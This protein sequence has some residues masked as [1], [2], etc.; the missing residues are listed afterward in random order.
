MPLSI[1]NLTPEETSGPTTL[2]K[3]ATFQKFLD[4]L[5]M[6]RLYFRRIDKLTDPFEGMMPPDLYSPSSS[7][8]AEIE[9]AAILEKHALYIERERTKVFTNS[10]HQ[11]EY[12]SEA[13]WKIFGGAGHSIAITAKLSSLVKALRDQDLTLGKVLYK[14]TIKDD[15]TLSD[16]FD[17]ALLKRKPFEHEREFRLLYINNDGEHSP[18]LLDEN[19]LHIHVEP[20]DIIEAIYVS[21]LSEPWQAEL[22]QHI[23]AREGLAERVIL[24]TLFKYP[25][26]SRQRRQ[27]RE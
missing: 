27:P 3:Y 5:L 2:W 15:F 19:G 22:T 26:S 18:K 24:S 17:F 21:P 9:A 16:I 1:R 25:D 10:W 23:V 20:K 11:N 7:G 4:F 6:K 13:M 14:D 12:E 8:A